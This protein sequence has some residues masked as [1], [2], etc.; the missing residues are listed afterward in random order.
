[1]SYVQ[2]LTKRSHSLP[3]QLAER[4]PMSSASPPPVERQFGQQARLL[5]AAYFQPGLPNSPFPVP[6][7]PLDQAILTSIH[8]AAGN[9]DIRRR[10][11]LG[12]IMLIG[13]ASKTPNLAMFLETRL[14]ALMPQYPKEIL[15]VAPPREMDP[16]VLVWK[17]GSVFGRLSSSGNDSWIY[18]REYDLLG[19][20]LL[21]QK[22]MWN[23]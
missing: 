6:L 18:G 8:H 7:M 10:D 12:S 14:R 1:M 15:V 5:P 4:S 22:C 9:N 21:A 23:W 2:L 16:S 17:G 3:E 19:S 20:K 11:L 13:G